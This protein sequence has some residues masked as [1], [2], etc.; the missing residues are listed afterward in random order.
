MKYSQLKKRLITESIVALGIL[1]IVGGITY[2][3]SFMLEDYQKQSQDL[4]LLVAKATTERTA[5][6]GKFDKTKQNTDLYVE[7]LKKNPK[8]GLY[9]NR[10]DIEGQFKLFQ[11]AYDVNDIS[12]TV[13]PPKELKDVK[14]K[15]P[16]GTVTVSDLKLS[17]N[18]LLDDDAF[19]MIDAMQKDLLGVAKI[20]SLKLTRNEDISDK[21]LQTVETKGTYPLVKADITAAWLAIKPPETPAKNEAPKP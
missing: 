5:L 21:V 3:L 16:A 19:A 8:S 17:F 12:L 2:Y 7:A 10:Q 18:T 15:K 11:Q 13:S 9:T 4:E 14:Y 1:A 20:V 6:T